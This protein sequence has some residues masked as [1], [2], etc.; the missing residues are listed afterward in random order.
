MCKPT[1]FTN[2]STNNKVQVAANLKLSVNTHVPETKGPDTFFGVKFLPFPQ[3]IPIIGF[4]TTHTHPFY[5]ML[6]NNRALPR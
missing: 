2:D 4:Y 3:I 1:M 6:I 5:V